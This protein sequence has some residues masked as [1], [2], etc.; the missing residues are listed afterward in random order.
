MNKLKV[1]ALS[2]VLALAARAHWFL[3]KFGGIGYNP[4]SGRGIE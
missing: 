2:F 3:R 1:R 4:G